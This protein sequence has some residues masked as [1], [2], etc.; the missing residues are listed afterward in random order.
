MHTPT[1]GI[2]HHFKDSTKEY[3]V[4]GVAFNT[5]TEELM[6]V[7]KPL[8][9][10]DYTMFVRPLSM[11]MEDVDK[12]ELGYKGPRFIRLRDA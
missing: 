1:P 10:T 4:L 2:Y 5:E 6:V 7:Y 9:E 11:F 3:E 12:P 8:Y